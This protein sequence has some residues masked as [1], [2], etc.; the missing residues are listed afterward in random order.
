MKGEGP[1]TQKEE[2]VLRLLA[3]H[4]TYEDIRTDLHISITTLYC[5]IQSLMIK[6]DIH[7]KELLIKYAID[8]GYGRKI[9]V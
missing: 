5:H 8:N 6:T 4:R 9:A 2:Q 7:K 3:E 1:I